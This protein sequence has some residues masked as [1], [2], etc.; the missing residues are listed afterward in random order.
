MIP[1]IRRYLK[2]VRYLGS[3]TAAVFA[4]GWVEREMERESFSTEDGPVL[5]VC[6]NTVPTVNNTVLNT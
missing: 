4:R 1:L 5:E 3:K 2:I 6:Y